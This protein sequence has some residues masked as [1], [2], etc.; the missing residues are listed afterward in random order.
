MRSEEKGVRVS[1]AQE[2]YRDIRIPYGP[3]GLLIIKQFGCP[4]GTSFLA[5]I[6]LFTICAN[7]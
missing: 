4:V 1:L 5:F 3:M 6:L 2:D 7:P